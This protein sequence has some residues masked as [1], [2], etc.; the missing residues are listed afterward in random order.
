MARNDKDILRVDNKTLNYAGKTI[1][2]RNIAY[3]EKY[4]V[5]K[6]NHFG[7]VLVI[8]ILVVVGT[9]AIGSQGARRGPP[10]DLIAAAAGVLFVVYAVWIA[11]LAFRR[12][13]YAMSLQT[14][15]GDA[16]RWFASND[17]QFLDSLIRE[18][19][20]RI[21][22]DGTLPPLIANIHE[23]TIHYGD[24]IMGDQVR[25][26]KTKIMG[27]QVKFGNIS[28]QATVIV[29][30]GLVNKSFNKTRQ[31]FDE[32]TAQALRKLAAF[33]EA[34]QNQDAIE[35]FNEFNKELIS[36]KPRKSMLKLLWN[37]IK[38][39]LPAVNTLGDIALKIAAIVA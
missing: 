8:T 13:K 14:T 18:L 28:G 9:I 11:S 32:E 10:P 33:I 1:P 17:E 25:G 37:G 7:V 23:N 34:S 15:A 26:D 2:L 24:K 16:V 5:K 35:H 4:R 27:D 31:R 36:E 21:E 29:N 20:A 39:A 38:E 12:P 19:T 3:F 30:R 6:D 22:D